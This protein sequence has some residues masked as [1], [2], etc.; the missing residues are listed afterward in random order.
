M[1][2]PPRKPARPTRAKASR[3]D[4]TPL[5]EH[6]AALPALVDDGVLEPQRKLSVRLR[7]KLAAEAATNLDVS[8]ILSIEQRLMGIADAIGDRY[9]SDN[10][11]RNSLDRPAELA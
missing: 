4:V 11:R 7:G 2:K 8:D 1:S 6:L 9:F 10:A 5:D 3:P